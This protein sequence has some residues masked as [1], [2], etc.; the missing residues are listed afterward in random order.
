MITIKLTSS[1]LAQM[2]FC[3]SPLLESV[4]SL[5]ALLHPD[6]RRA[7]HAPWF[8]RARSRLVRTDLT[9]LIAVLP[10]QWYVPDFLTPPPTGSLPDF[11]S[12]LSALCATPPE[13]VRNE[14]DLEYLGKPLPPAA[15][16]LLEAPADGLQV[17]ADQLGRY[18]DLVLADCWTEIRTMLGTEMMNQ[19]RE[20][21]SS[22][23]HLLLRSLHPDVSWENESL[24]INSSRE[25]V[26]VE[27]HRPGLVILPSVF[28]WPRVSAMIQ[29]AWPATLVYSPP[30]VAT[31]WG[32][33]RRKRRAA[34]AALIGPTRAIMLER[35]D[36]PLSTTELARQLQISMSCTSYHL[37]VLRDAGLLQG[38]RQGRRVLYGR[39]AA[40][41]TLMS[42]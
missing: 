4:A 23:S 42:G 37:A 27:S 5:F 30:S 33:P 8:R 40:G 41:E 6:C 14:I 9:N 10:N 7:L 20:L 3:S 36:R 16:R 38:S 22:G 35:L 34:L 2:R 15:H 28:A 19:A 26:M 25:N 24:R 12:E 39:T 11:S 13:Q 21:V 29:P 1:D 32:E 17:I 18:F 31:L